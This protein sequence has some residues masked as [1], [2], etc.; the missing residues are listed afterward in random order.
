MR[1]R[2]RP[3]RRGVGPHR[4]RRR[5]QRQH[6]T[7]RGTAGLEELGKIDFHHGDATPGELAA[8]RLAHAMDHDHA[9]EI[10]DLQAS[11]V[12][13][14]SDTTMRSERANRSSIVASERR[15]KAP[16]K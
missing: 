7:F 8:K 6:E 16:G 10:D 2:H 3:L 4:F 1:F 15:E 14:S 13:S 9:T 12:A 11:A 5:R